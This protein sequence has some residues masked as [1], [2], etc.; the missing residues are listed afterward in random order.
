MADLAL[1]RRHVG[2]DVAAFLIALIVG[3]VLYLGYP[4][5]SI[6]GECTTVIRGSTPSPDRSKVVVVFRRDCGATVPFNTQA[7]IAPAGDEFSSDKSP[8]FFTVSGTPEVMVTWLEE[9]TVEIAVI[10][11]AD[12][13]F[14]S[15]QSVAGV[16]VLY[17]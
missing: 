5:I 12:R 8:A 14:K 15:E 17:K 9:A 1:K 4:S 6:F 11:G 2:R 7:S 13:I 16:K 10:P 3:G